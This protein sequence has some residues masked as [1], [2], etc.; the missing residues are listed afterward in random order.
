[1]NVRY[2]F[3]FSFIILVLIAAG[4]AL[5]SSGGPPR[6]RTG[7][8]A[9][10]AKTAETTC[11]ACH[12]D[13][14]L[15]DGTTLTLIGA[16]T[17]YSAGGVYTFTVEIASNQTA[18]SPDRVWAFELTAIDMA[19]GDGTGTFA[20]VQDT[21]IIVGTGQYATRSYIESYTDRPGAS[22]PVQWQVQWT[23]P[24][25]SVGSVGFYAA[26]IAGDGTGGNDGDWVCSTSARAEDI[27]PVE[28]STWGKVKALYRR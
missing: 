24:S 27:T 13:Y 5:A 21:Q 15:N 14:P 8:P 6:S 9:V 1:M 7:A 12:N 17:T 22:T 19:N 3:L 11:L 23:A 20:N 25:P 28:A 16:P 2:R 4:I 26:G 18:I 10:G